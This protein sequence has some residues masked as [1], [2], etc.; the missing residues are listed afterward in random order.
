MITTD[1]VG[2]PDGM[3]GEDRAAHDPLGALAILPSIDLAQPDRRGAPLS[4][5]ELRRERGG[6][7]QRAP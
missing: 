2:E 6:G 5:T 7:A 4:G 3:R 1:E